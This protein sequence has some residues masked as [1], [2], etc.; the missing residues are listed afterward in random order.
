VGV[1]GADPAEAGKVDAVLV[2]EDA[3]HPDAGGLGVGAHAD[4]AAF[5]VLRPKLALRGVVDDGVVLEARH[6]HGG[7]QHQR[8]AVGLG[9]QEM[10]MASSPASNAPR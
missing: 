2:H 5:Q 10:P 7:Q 9:L 6:H 1:V 8:P 3:A 4:A